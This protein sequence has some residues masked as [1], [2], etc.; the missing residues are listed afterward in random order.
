MIKLDGSGDSAQKEIMTLKAEVDSLKERLSNELTLNKQIEKDLIESNAWVKALFQG[1]HSVILIVD[2]VTGVIRD[3]N[4]AAS[5]YYGWTHAELCKMN[6]S[7]IN[8]LTPEEIFSEIQLAKEEKRKFFL[9]RH[10]LANGSIRD[11]EVFSGPI[12]FDNLNLLYSHIQDI[13]ER[14]TTEDALRTSEIKYRNLIE[15]INDVVYEI[16]NQGV[17]KYIS[18]SVTRILGYDPNEVIGKNFIDFVGVNSE[19]LLSRLEELKIQ[20]KVESEY[21][22]SNKHGGFSWIRFS[23]NAVKIDGQLVGVTGTLFDITES[24]L[25]QLA[26]ND[27]TNLLT[28]LIINLQEGILLEDSERKIVLTNQLFCEMFGIPVPPEAMVGAD[29][30]NSAEQSKGF[31]IDP[32]KFMSDINTILKNKIA[33]FNDELELVDGRYF[34]RDYIPTYIENLYNGHLWKYRDITNRKQAENKLKEFNEILENRINERTAQLSSSNKILKHE[35]TERKL[36]EEELRRLTSRLTLAVHAGGVGVWDYDIEKNKLTWDDQ[37]FK[38]YGISKNSFSGEYDAWENGL[39]PDDR[40]RGDIEIQLAISGEKDFDTEFR[41]VW[42]NGRIRNIR[43]LAIVHRDES[44][45]PLQ[46]VGTNWDIT[47]QKLAEKELIDAKNEADKANLAK[48]EFLSRMSHE[49]R[50][51]M[52]SI[53]GFAQLMEMGKLPPEQLKCVKHILTSGRHLLRLINE[54]LDLAGIES[55]KVVLS[56][57]PVNLH[58]VIA[59]ISEMIQPMVSARDIRFRVIPSEYIQD[60]VVADYQRLRQVL[61][62]LLNNAVKYNREGGSIEVNIEPA[63]LNTIGIEFLRV[64]IRDTGFGITQEDIFK[65]FKPFVRIGAEKT[66]TEG[67]G[68]G[69]SLVKKLMEAMGGTIGVNSNPGE[70]STFWIELPKSNF[71]VPKA[72]SQLKTTDQKSDIQQQPATILYIEDNRSNIELVEQIFVNSR[73]AIRLITK[74]TGNETVELALQHQPDLILLDLDLPDIHGSQVIEQLQT[75]SKTKD[76]PVVII[77]ADAMPSQISSLLSA[78]ARDYLTKPLDIKAFLKIIDEYIIIKNR[79]I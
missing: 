4:P 70:G 57:E 44:G 17:I 64:S 74:S 22:I 40:L 23:S 53:L 73:N 12:R 18:S 14:K 55:G 29:C 1:N 47:G 60:S 5:S 72:L 21:K 49:L 6:I 50:T 39:H 30:S 15:N 36:I 61:L 75:E 58:H 59:E 62:N 7:Q 8:T 11:V 54:V 66:R 48:S 77:S 76:I 13:T 33:V 25:S 69:L 19:Y 63:P 32:D 10:R 71:I 34:E 42:P 26:L 31:F 3:A 28:N 78:G 2:P 20:D 35:I 37:M 46:I 79:R 27:K 45:K 68:L 16:D 43:A 65:L 24:K 9:F 38:L 56:F 52:N 51:P 67:S 41:V